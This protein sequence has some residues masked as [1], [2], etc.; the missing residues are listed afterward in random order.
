MFSLLSLLPPTFLNHIYPNHNFV[1][2]EQVLVFSLWPYLIAPIA[3]LLRAASPLHVPTH[4]SLCPFLGTIPTTDLP[5][6]LIC[7]LPPLPPPPFAFAVATPPTTPTLPTPRVC[8]SYS[9]VVPWHVHFLCWHHTR[10]PLWNCTRLC[11]AVLSHV[12]T[13][14][15]WRQC[16]LH[17]WILRAESS[18]LVVSTYLLLAGPHHDF[19]DSLPLCTT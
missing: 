12:S 8:T 2:S 18:M 19:E 17:R 16:L 3:P 15:H 6:T 7:P 5:P 10:D 4:V 9:H 13:T 1:G 14:S 11:L